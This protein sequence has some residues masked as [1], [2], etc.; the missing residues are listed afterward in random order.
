LKARIREFEEAAEENLA[1]IQSLETEKDQYI[2]G[3]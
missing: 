3:T 1:R 2:A